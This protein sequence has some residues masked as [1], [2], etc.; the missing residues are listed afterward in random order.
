MKNSHIGELV[1]S[2]DQI[3]K[4]GQAIAGKLNA[5]YQDAVIITVVPEGSSLVCVTFKTAEVWETY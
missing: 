4:G 3:Q 1:L 2:T 5:H